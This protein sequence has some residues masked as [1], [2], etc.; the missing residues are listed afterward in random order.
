MKQS[1][2]GP[3]SLLNGLSKV[4]EKVFEYCDKSGL[5]PKNQFGFIS[6]HSAVHDPMR[7]FEEAIMGS[8]GQ[9]DSLDT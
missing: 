3:I 6:N 2:L 1:I 7:L 8:Q 5:L 4:F 9:N